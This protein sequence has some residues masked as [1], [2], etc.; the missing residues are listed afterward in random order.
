MAII[1]AIET[2]SDTVLDE[3]LP[4]PRDTVLIVAV[5]A[6]IATVGGWLAWQRIDQLRDALERRNRELEARTATTR[7]LHQV[8]IAIAALADLDAILQVIVDSARTLLEADV[9]VLARAAP[10]G[11]LHLAAWTGAPALIVRPPEVPDDIRAFVAPEAL[12]SELAA[13][14][15][16]GDATVGSLAVGSRN[17]RAYGVEQIETLA[18]LA[19]QA[20]IAIENARL[21]D[22]LRET[23]VRGERE[24]IARELH[25][26]LAQVL[27]YVNTKSQAV[28]GLLEVGRTQEARSH[29]AELA[30]AARSVYVDVREAI[31]GLS[32]PILEGSGLVATVERYAERFAEA[33]KLAVHIEASDVARIAD[34]PPTV[35]AQA[36]RI[37][38][39][40]LTNVRKHA[41]ANRVAITLDVRAETLV[42]DVTD[43][44]RGLDG[45]A[46]TPQAWPRYGLVSMRERA[47]SVGGTVE[48]EPA[49]TGGTRVRLRIPL[50]A[51]TLQASDSGAPARVR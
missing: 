21:Q 33:S 43:D 2:L 9:A 31:L 24:R 49:P 37:V 48:I 14:L 45:A 10:D 11:T 7:A 25:D 41:S 32:T 5:V 35:E 3:L 30:S 40:A 23:A 42:L 8:A 51:A 50:G 22:R 28:E 38:Q 47:A 13:P 39:E 29:L 19:N 46:S 44:G 12:A 16:R 27:G 26:G 6:A 18:T 4:F 34:L 36:F 20:S 17:A 15:R 1:A